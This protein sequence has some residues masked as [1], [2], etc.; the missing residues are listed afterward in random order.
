[1]RIPGSVTLPP[2][3]VAVENIS[4]ALIDGIDDPPNHIMR[5]DGSCNWSA[6]VRSR[7]STHRTVAGIGV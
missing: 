4:S 7:A 6:V 5:P 3:S 1:M 2:E